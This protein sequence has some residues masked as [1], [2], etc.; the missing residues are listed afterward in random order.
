MG[1]SLGMPW[2]IETP[3]FVFPFQ[4][5]WVHATLRTG[6]SKA[7]PLMQP[8]QGLLLGQ[9]D[10]VSGSSRALHPTRAMLSPVPPRLEERLQ[11][12]QHQQ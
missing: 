12:L 2:G 3:S 5:C 1:A 8:L 11:L 9:G 7:S 6:L 4:T 10:T